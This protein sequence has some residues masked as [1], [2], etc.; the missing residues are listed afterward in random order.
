M[1][2]GNKLLYICTNESDTAVLPL[3]Y[4]C[5]Q[6]TSFYQTAGFVKRQKTWHSSKAPLFQYIYTKKIA[7]SNNMSSLRIKLICNFR[8]YSCGWLSIDRSRLPPE[9][10]PSLEMANETHEK[11]WRSRS[12]VFFRRSCN[13]IVHNNGSQHQVLFKNGR[14]LILDL[15]QHECVEKQECI[16]KKSY[17]FALG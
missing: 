12:F 4:L 17:L 13:P 1:W 6:A 5:M 8:N 9:D 11:F 16:E 7:S 2:L 14:M 10:A 15:H 3:L